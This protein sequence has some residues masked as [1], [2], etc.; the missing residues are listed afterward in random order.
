MSHKDLDWYNKEKPVV[1]WIY[2]PSDGQ[3]PSESPPVYHQDNSELD[4][5]GKSDAD[6]DL[7]P[8]VVDQLCANMSYNDWVVIAVEHL[9]K[10][11]WVLSYQ[12]S[13]KPESI[14]HSLCMYPEMFS[15]LFLMVWIDLRMSTWSEAYQERTI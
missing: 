6:L 7:C 1:D 3:D 5:A 8:F 9:C 14:Y 12:Q 11:R 13:S 10:S 15:W 2:L 4:L